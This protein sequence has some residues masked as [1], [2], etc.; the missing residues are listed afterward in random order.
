MDTGGWDLSGWDTSETGQRILRKLDPPRPVLVDLN[1]ALPPGVGRPPQD[2][3]PLYIPAF[4][5]DLPF[6]APGHQYA[7]IRQRTSRWW[8]IVSVDTGAT[9]RSSRLT[10]PLL[11]APENVALDTPEQREKRLIGNRPPWLTQWERDSRRGP[12][13]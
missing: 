11:V 13:G 3:Q 5:L 4:G 6:W 1:N 10:I 7:W 2:H 8:A 9:N 12:R